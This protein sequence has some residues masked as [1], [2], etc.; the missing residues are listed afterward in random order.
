MVN[1]ITFYIRP[2]EQPMSDERWSVSEKLLMIG[3][4]VLLA[5]IFYLLA[6]GHRI[7]GAG[8]PYP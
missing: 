2:L 4:A 3:L 5:V 8:N 1:Y 7:V 6:T